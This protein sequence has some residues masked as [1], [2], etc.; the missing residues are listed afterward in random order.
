MNPLNPIDW[1]LKAHRDL[2]L[3]NH[4]SQHKPEY[5]DLI[6]YHCQQAAE[7]F[8]LFAKNTLNP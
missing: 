5:P 1:L 8:S 2:G 4:A 7:F 6:C 3:A